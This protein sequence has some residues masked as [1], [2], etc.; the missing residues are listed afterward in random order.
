MNSEKVDRVEKQIDHHLNNRKCESC[1]VKGKSY[2]DCFDNLFTDALSV[3]RELKAE[4]ER[5]KDK[6]INAAKRI[7]KLIEQ[8]R[9]SRNA[10]TMGM[11][12]GLRIALE[13]IC[14]EPK[15]DEQN[16]S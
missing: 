15:E 6:R 11:V 14:D 12:G 8:H 3:I 2:A 10:D 13:I 1:S 16:D 7:E 5:L 9:H 4:N